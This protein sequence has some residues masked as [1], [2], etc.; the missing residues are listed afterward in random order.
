MSPAVSLHRSEQKSEGFSLSSAAPQC[1]H[2]S[3]AHVPDMI[4]ASCALVP[5]SSTRKSGNF[6]E[7]AAQEREGALSRPGPAGSAFSPGDASTPE[8]SATPELLPAWKGSSI[9][10]R[11]EVPGPS[12]AVRAPP[13]V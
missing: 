9:D 7:R 8:D 4:P 13:R 2:S 12:R 6:A 10:D 11:R 1:A 5:T 3:R